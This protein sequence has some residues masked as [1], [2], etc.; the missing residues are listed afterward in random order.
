MIVRDY[1]A[2]DI[3]DEWDDDP[4]EDDDTTDPCS[5]C[6]EP[7]YDDAERCPH[8]GLYLS[9]EDRPYRKPWWVVLGAMA[10]LAVVTWWILHP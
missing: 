7:V 3:D 9:R 10:C 2:D 5:H 6:G 4:D 1:D 8:C